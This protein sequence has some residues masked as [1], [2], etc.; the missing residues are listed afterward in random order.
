MSQVYI[1]FQSFRAHGLISMDGQTATQ[2]VFRNNCSKTFSEYTH[3]RKRQ[4]SREKFWWAGKPQ[5]SRSLKKINKKYFVLFFSLSLCAV[6]R[7]KNTTHERLKRHPNGG[8][9]TTQKPLA[10]HGRQQHYATKTTIVTKPV[11][12]PLSQKRIDNHA[13]DQPICMIVWTARQ[14]VKR[15]WSCRHPSSAIC[16]CYVDHHIKMGHFLL[17]V[18]AESSTWTQKGN[19]HSY[20]RN[21]KKK[22]GKP[23]L[24]LYLLFLPG[25]SCFF[26]L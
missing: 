16:V 2:R 3:G 14:S 12:P 8:R 19:V 5:E 23:L 10:Q 9:P 25:A 6:P 26:F 24:P 21:N 22:K 4:K 20:R 18:S 13:A 17:Y 1:R 15:S 7:T 11:H